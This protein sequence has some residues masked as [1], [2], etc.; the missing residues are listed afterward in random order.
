MGIFHM[1]MYVL[2]ATLIMKKFLSVYQTISLI[3]SIF[4]CYSVYKSSF[5]LLLLFLLILFLS[6][7]P[8]FLLSS[9]LPLLLVL[10]QFLLSLILSYLLVIASNFLCCYSYQV[11]ITITV[12]IISFINFLI[13][14]LTFYLR[15]S[16]SQVFF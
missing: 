1:Y 5:S 11:N 13:Y 6:L 15:I 4:L 2:F 7:K 14:I 3:K 12:S 16:A 9:L 10:L 8:L